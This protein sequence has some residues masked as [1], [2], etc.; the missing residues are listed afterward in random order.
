MAR[1]TLGIEHVD[2]LE[3]EQAT[4]LR[5]KMILMTI[6]GELP[7]NVAAE[8]LGVG[9][10]RFHEL[11]DEALSGALEALAPKP[12]GRQPSAAGEHVRVLELED[13]LRLAHYQLEVERVRAQ[14]L[15][16]M[17]GVVLG[18]PLPP[19]EGRGGGGRHTRS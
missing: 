16:T 3:G 14:L 8:R 5:L 12:A 11:R 1:P 19:L 9:P 4:K 10:S 2:K 7:V 6:S 15:L 18:K 13:E 17:P